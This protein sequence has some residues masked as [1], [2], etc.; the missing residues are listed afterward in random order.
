VD[1]NQDLKNWKATFALAVLCLIGGYATKKTELETDP[2]M[3]VEFYVQE[4]P[5][6]VGDF[7]IIKYGADWPQETA[8]VHVKAG[9]FITASEATPKMLAAYSQVI[10][11]RG[12]ESLC[13][14]GQEIDFDHCL[15]CNHFAVSVVSCNHTPRRSTYLV[16]YH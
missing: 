15:K 4:S 6:H 3:V 10:Q 8:E 11:N 1:N 16:T 14:D 9:H 13:V 12:D 5:D 7:G 2:R